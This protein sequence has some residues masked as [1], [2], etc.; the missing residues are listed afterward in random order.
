MG[1]LIVTRLFDLGGLPGSPPLPRD[2]GENVAAMP[3]KEA[4][5]WV[6]SRG[7]RCYGQWEKGAL[8]STLADLELLRE[9]WRKRFEGTHPLQSRLP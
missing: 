3:A 8:D 4:E 6:T 2:F 9:P 5:E 1:E 7:K